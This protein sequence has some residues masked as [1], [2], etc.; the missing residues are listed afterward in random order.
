MN[1]DGAAHAR[2][3]HRTGPHHRPPT[4]DHTTRA[5]DADHARDTDGTGSLRTGGGRVNRDGRTGRGGRAASRGGC[6]G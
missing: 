6:T 1:R 2:Q 4:G 3:T 5:H